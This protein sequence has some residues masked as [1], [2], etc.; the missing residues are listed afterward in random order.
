MQIVKTTSNKTSG[1]VFEKCIWN[2]LLSLYED[3]KATFLLMN[4]ARQSHSKVYNH[5]DER[6]GQLGTVTLIFWWNEN[7]CIMKIFVLLIV[8]KCS[9]EL[10]RSYNLQILSVLAMGQMRYEKLCTLSYIVI[11]VSVAEIQATI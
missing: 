11:A 1:H 4:K 2:M 9:E 10:N 8:L 6:D 5:W 7:V 3:R